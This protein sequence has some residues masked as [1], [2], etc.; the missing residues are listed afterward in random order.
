MSNEIDL[1]QFYSIFVEESSELIEAMEA[2]LLQLELGDIDDEIVNT[3]FRAAHSI[4]GSGATLGFNEIADFTHGVE[5]MLEEMRS[6]E[7]PVTKDGISL[8]LEC[9]DCLRGMI[10]RCTTNESNDQALIAGLSGQLE[11]LLNTVIPAGEDSLN[12]STETTTAATTNTATTNTWTISFQPHRNLFFTGNDPFRLLR[13]LET[14]GDLKVQVN[15]EHL[16]GFVD[17]DPQQCHLGWDMTLTGQIEEDQI[18]DVFAW[19]ED[20]CDLT[21]TLQR[22]KQEVDDPASSGV[23]DAAT[24]SEGQTITD[25][26][27]APNNLK[28][29]PE[30]QS[31]ESE[32]GKPT[33]AAGEVAVT[34]QKKKRRATDTAALSDGFGEETSSIR[35]STDKVDDLVNLV[36]ELVITQSILTQATKN[37][38][39]VQMATLTHSL[40]QLERNTRD[41]QEQALNIRMLPISFAFQRLPRIVHDLNRSLGKQVKLKFTGESTELDKTVLEKIGDPLVHLVRNALDHGIEM[42]EQRRAAGKEENGTIEVKAFYQGGSILIEVSDDGSGLDTDKIL[43]KAKEKSLVDEEAELTTEQIKNLVFEPGFST[44]DKVSNISGRGVGMDVVRRNITDLGGRVEVRSERG[45]GTIFTIKLPLTLAI[46]DGQMVQVGDQVYVVP[47]LAI[48]ESVKVKPG[49]IHRVAGEA[50]V[51]KYRNDCLPV[52][53]LSEAF[54]VQEGRLSLVDGLLV[55]VDVD[56]QLIGLNI[57][58]VL[59]QQQVVVKSLEKNF[60]EVPGISGA[61]ILGD[62]SVALIVDVPALVQLSLTHVA[63]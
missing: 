3:I 2:G 44:A 49:D 27:K 32:A 1:S 6:G 33:P 48:V 31:S 37:I 17:L 10:K 59:G 35:V 12:L 29:A 28:A 62:G 23:V 11:S 18:R 19:V 46:L 26:L 43:Q 22:S 7:R 20:D 45:R 25:E 52:V 63:A 42:P 9:V 56:G 5:A 8:L 4:K 14:M 24:V 38:D 34:E 61:T 15:T 51:Y 53:R 13:E 57:D 54:G 16:P 40:Q 30:K 39:P 36:G 60:R 55:I 21:L 41:L 58:D 50:E 47:L